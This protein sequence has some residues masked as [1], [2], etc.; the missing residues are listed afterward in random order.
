MLRI[1]TLY[2]V[3]RGGKSQ[4]QAGLGTLNIMMLG[5]HRGI[6]LHQTGSFTKQPLRESSNNAPI[7]PRW[8]RGR[9]IRRTWPR[10]FGGGD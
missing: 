7:Y 8:Y 10:H 3:P 2:F 4:D 9:I 5:K 1:N 6:I